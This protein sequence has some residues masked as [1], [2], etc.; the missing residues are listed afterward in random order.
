MLENTRLW[1]DSSSMAY[2]HGNKED[3]RQ[4]IYDHLGT[5]CEKFKTTKFNFISEDSRTNFRN[6]VAVS[7]EYKGQRRTKKNVDLIKSYLPNLGLALNEIN[8]TFRADTYY[9]VENDD[10]ISILAT[11]IPNSVMCAN[12]RDYLATPGVYYNIKTNRVHAIQYPG[13]ILLNEKKKIEAKGYYQIYSQLLKGS[14]KENYKGIE[15]MGDI[16]VFNVLKDLK[17]ETEMK[18][19]CT[20]L[21]TD[22]YGIEEGIKKLE[23]G[24]KLSWILTH[25]S[26]LVTPN[27]IEF[28][29]IKI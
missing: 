8:T 27:A 11:R 10:V 6:E 12:D 2:I 3:C 18:Q 1:I 26:S 22:F 25:N 16:S 13:S 17:T 19:V 15:G 14:T 4:S 7:N 9:G 29:D 28:T 21:F 20:Q 24:F 5:L 23:E